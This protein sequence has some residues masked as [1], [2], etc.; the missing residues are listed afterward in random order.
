MKSLKEQLLENYFNDEN[1]LRDVI[2]SKSPLIYQ[3][4]SGLLDALKTA[5]LSESATKNR[6]YYFLVIL[7]HFV[8]KIPLRVFTIRNT[9]ENFIKQSEALFEL[10]NKEQKSNNMYLDASL[11]NGNSGARE[12]ASKDYKK[13]SLEFLKHLPESEDF[14][15]YDNLERH[16]ALFDVVNDDY[17]ATHDSVFEDEE[18]YIFDCT[19]DQIPSKDVEIDSDDSILANK[20]AEK[21]NEGDR[22]SKCPK[23]NYRRFLALPLGVLKYDPTESLKYK[24]PE[25]V[26][27][28]V[29]YLSMPLFSHIC[30]C[31]NRNPDYEKKDEYDEG[32][33]FNKNTFYNGFYMV[34]H[35]V[36]N[37]HFAI[38]KNGQYLLAEDF[39]LDSKL[40]CV[41]S[42]FHTE[43]NVG[44]HRHV[45][46]A[47]IA[48]AQRLL[49]GFRPKLT[50]NDI[51]RV[52]QIYLNDSN[53][54]TELKGV[55]QGN[56][57][58]TQCSLDAQKIWFFD[59][60]VE[61]II[62]DLDNDVLWRL[63]KSGIV[64]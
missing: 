56:K 34:K 27:K 33:R 32:K 35:Q 31:L 8:F 6:G 57:E 3:T 11:F 59:K 7:L 38:L 29:D 30:R 39:V 45:A 51:R 60:N 20:D 24:S 37:T 46:E 41:P 43:E 14:I 53:V 16:N 15:V 17:G 1:E 22:Q 36:R 61:K 12:Y 64:D 21:T 9:N 26:G 62:Y 55:L 47:Y 19:E 42:I 50:R 10:L 48:D 2:N 25:L 49:E 44:D 40:R 18:E 63:T 54:K 52:L 4:S 28:V 13:A 58:I 23:I 5:K